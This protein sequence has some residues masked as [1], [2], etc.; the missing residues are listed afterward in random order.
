MIIIVK[1]S[2]PQ[3]KT[4]ATTASNITCLIPTGWYCLIKLY[5]FD[6]H[7][8]TAYRIL[9]KF[10]ILA[11]QRLISRFFFWSQVYKP[12]QVVVI[13]LWKSSILAF[14]QGKLVKF[15]R[16]ATGVRPRLKITFFHFKAFLIMPR[17]NP[18]WKI[19]WTN[20]FYFAQ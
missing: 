15:S 11:F 14:S 7:F 10:W 13:V 4:K 18:N 2:Q 6:C 8:K 16:A 9:I 12:L 5:Y 3:P 1:L 17:D 20:N 19:S